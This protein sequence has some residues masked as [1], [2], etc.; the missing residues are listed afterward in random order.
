M[1][2][3]PLRP[4]VGAAVVVT[5]GWGAGYPLWAQGDP[6]GFHR[7]PF[8]PFEPLFMLLVGLPLA[9]AAGWLTVAPSKRTRAGGYVVLSLGAVV[10]AYLGSFAFFG[11][12]CFDPGDRCVTTW[13]TRV[14]VLAAALLAL[15]SGV[16]LN[17]WRAR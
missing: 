3:A 1:A 15:V 6:A 9:T 10:L 13:P 12:I 16:T 5:I 7:Q 17:R 4:W 8:S 14:T 2:A 11:G